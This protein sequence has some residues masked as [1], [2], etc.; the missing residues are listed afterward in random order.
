VRDDHVVMP[1]G[2]TMLLPGDEVL[3]LVTTDA[4]EQLRTMLT[5][6]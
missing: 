6:A 2:D 5:G 1:R 3:A 4:E